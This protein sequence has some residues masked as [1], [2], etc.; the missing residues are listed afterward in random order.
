MGTTNRKPP[1]SKPPRLSGAAAT[2]L[3]IGCIGLV[4]AV[5]GLVQYWSQGVVTIGT[6]REPMSG[7]EALAALAVLAV[8]S[9]AFCVGGMVLRF[10]ARQLSRRLRS[11]TSEER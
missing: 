1:A 11:R 5:A 3:V 10:R 2:A 8:V 4:G 6:G 9:S 7:T